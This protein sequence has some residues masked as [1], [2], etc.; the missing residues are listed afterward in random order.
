MT[1]YDLDCSTGS[2]IIWKARTWK[3]SWENFTGLRC[4]WRRNNESLEFNLHTGPLVRAWRAGAWHFELGGM[5]REL[6]G[7]DGCENGFAIGDTG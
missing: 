5:S 1:L 2:L 6:E 7:V 3:E 4:C